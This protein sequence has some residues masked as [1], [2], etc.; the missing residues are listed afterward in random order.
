MSSSEVAHASIQLSDRRT[1]AFED[2]GDPKEFPV[3]YL[4]G[5]PSSGSEWRMWGSEELLE[6]SGVRL[7]AIDRPGVG[8]SSY[9]AHRT[10]ASTGADL[11]EMASLLG[12]PRFGVFGYSGGAAYALAGALDP[13]CVA[14]AVVEGVLPPA[15]G[16]M[17]GLDPQSTRFLGIARKR[18]GMFGLAYRGNVLLW[19]RAPEK[20]VENALASF[21]TADKAEFARPE[22]H[23]AIMGTRGSARGQRLDVALATSPWGLDL[24]GISGSTHI[25][26][27]TADRN[28]SV[29]M[30]R[31]LAAQIP[32]SRLTVLDG[33]GHISMPVRYAGQVLEDL[34]QT[35]DATR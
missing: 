20:F 22:V 16:L 14:A 29:A 34:R 21:D 27:G 7:L 9:D 30:A 5:I 11:S 3:F 1:L 18:F 17:D 35:A 2:V 15:P 32:N 4:H 13:R 23:N 8:G 25:W 24:T 28:A 33:E 26:Q 12:L 10:V 6:R 31:T 19:S